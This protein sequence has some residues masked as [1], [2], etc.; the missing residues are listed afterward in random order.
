MSQDFPFLG[1]GWSF[2]P[3]FKKATKEVAMT[4]GFEDLNK[5]LEIIITTK[6]GERI[7][8]P[9]FGCNLENT[10]FE[11]MNFAAIAYLENMIRTA[12]LYHEARID[13]EDI[14]LDFEG[15]KG[16]LWIKILYQVR[17]ANSRFNFVY[18]YYLEEA[19]SI[20]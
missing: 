2:P 18:P 5:S 9:Q 15:P 10:L 7:M 3:V 1:K 4:E 20:I 19:N 12:I 6:L 14:Q 11:S 16:V 13:V 8:R 17:N